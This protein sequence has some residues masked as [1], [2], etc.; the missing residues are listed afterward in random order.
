MALIVQKYGGTSVGDVDRIK[1]VARKIAKRYRAGDQLVVVVSAMAGDT[2]R[3]IDLAHKV[4]KCPSERE[5]DVLFASGEQVSVALV[6]IAL[7][8]LGLKAISML[9]HQARI[10]TD[11]IHSKAMIDKI[12][13]LRIRKAI[14]QGNIV[15]IAGCQG[16]DLQENITTLGRGGSDL[17]AVA[18]A[19]ALKAPCEI[20]TDVEGVFTADPNICPKAKK[21]TKIS[22]EEMLEL[23]GAGA[24][25]LQIRSVKMAMRYQVQLIVRSTFSEEEGTMVTREEAGMEKR[26][27][28]GVTCDTADILISM[29]GVPDRAGVAAEI[30]ESLAEAEIVVDLIIQN[31]G[32]SSGNTDLSFTLPKTDKLKAQEILQSL[33]D[34]FPKCDIQTEE[35]IAKVSIVGAGMRTHAGVASHM[36]ETL[37]KEGINIKRISTSEIKISCVIDAKYAE[38]AV[39]A[40]HD[41]FELDKVFA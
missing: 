9:G 15:V 32:D 25:V 37:A 30:F 3:L 27:V 40:L 33:K 10:Y 29:L 35:P 24:K 31:V 34:K 2:N 18:L 22:Y 28:S 39:R 7:H 41:A 6:T 4:S 5:Y 20:Y 8:T 14:D 23:A 36:F 17:T 19:A 13:A 11:S 21:L 38:L 16:V 26:S 1:F 12:D